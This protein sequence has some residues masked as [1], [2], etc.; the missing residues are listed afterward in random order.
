MSAV[1]TMSA[2][3]MQRVRSLVTEYYQVKRFT[4][5]ENAFDYVLNEYPVEYEALNSTQVDNIWEVIDVLDRIYAVF[6]SEAEY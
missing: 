5:Y 1:K 4:G 6:D 3:N 2:V